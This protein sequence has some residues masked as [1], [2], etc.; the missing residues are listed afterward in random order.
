M[1]SVRVA[2]GTGQYCT[3]YIHQLPRQEL[4]DEPASEDGLLKPS[5]VEPA[6]RGITD[7]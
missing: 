6:A 1:V 4:R 5:F 3:G 2:G 7:R